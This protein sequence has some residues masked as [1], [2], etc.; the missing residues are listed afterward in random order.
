MKRAGPKTL[1]ERLDWMAKNLLGFAEELEAVAWIEHSAAR[2][3]A[4]LPNSQPTSG[5]PT[6]TND[7]DSGH[8]IDV[9]PEDQVKTITL[10]YTEYCL[11]IEVV[12]RHTDTTQAP[13]W[14]RLS[15]RLGLS[16]AAD[17]DDEPNQNPTHFSKN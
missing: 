1:A 17:L 6:L 13:V 16:C 10:S 8:A 15:R 9:A 2:H 12:A 5:A 3:T 11:L 4:L 14:R 7:P